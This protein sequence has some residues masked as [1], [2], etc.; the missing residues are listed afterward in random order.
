MT[1]TSNSQSQ[2]LGGWT[3]NHTGLLDLLA[4]DGFHRN[5]SRP[6]DGDSWTVTGS[7]I[8]EIKLRAACREGE[9]SQHAQPSFALPNLAPARRA[10]PAC[11]SLFSY[12][13]LAS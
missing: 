5:I 11:Q 12:H 13:G 7:T 1:V 4:L 3:T 6:P 9:G 8:T 2:Q 10:S